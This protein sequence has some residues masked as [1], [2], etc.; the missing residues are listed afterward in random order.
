[1]NISNAE[2]LAI[3][4]VVCRALR[5]QPGESIVEAARRIMSAPRGDRAWPVAAAILSTKVPKGRR[6]DP[7][8]RMRKAAKIARQKGLDS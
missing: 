8:A 7:W 6:D 2:R 4:A 5:K 3:D 1:M